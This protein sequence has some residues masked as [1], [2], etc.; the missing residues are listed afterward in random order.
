MGIARRPA[1]DPSQR[2]D[3]R[4]AERFEQ[5]SV[6]RGERDGIDPDPD[7]QRQDGKDRETR[8]NEQGPGSE[9]QVTQHGVHSLSRR[10]A[11]GIGSG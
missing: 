1:H 5:E 2:L 9:S 6:Q 10:E 8:P 4:E 11:S 3:A 7:G